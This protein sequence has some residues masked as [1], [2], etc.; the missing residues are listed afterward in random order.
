M[1]YALTHANIYLDPGRFAEALLV[2]DGLIRAVGTDQEIEALAP[3]ETIDC[4]G[5]TLIPGFNDSHSHLLMV[6][7]NGQKLQLLD[8]QSIDEI[9][10]K[11]REFIQQRP[12]LTALVGMG[13]NPAEFS[14]GEKRNLHRYDLD[15][16]STEIPVML[17][18]AC[19]HTL[20][21][22]TKALEMAGV[23]KDTPQIDGGL[24]E[25]DDN[26]PN[27]RFFENARELVDHLQPTMTSEDLFQSMSETMNYALSNGITTVQTNDIGMVR[28]LEDTLK[29][30]RDLYAG[31]TPTIKT[32]HQL[33]FDTPQDFEKFI[34]STYQEELPAKMTWGPLKLFKDGTLGGRSALVS[35]AFL[36]SPGNTG[37][38]VLPIAKAK[39]F[40]DMAR[41]HGFQVYTHCIG[42]KAIEEMLEVYQPH[43]KDDRWALVHCQITHADTLEKMAEAG[44][45]AIIQPIFL[46][47]DVG[48]LQEALSPETQ[49]TSYAWKTMLKLGIPIAIGTDSPVEDLNPFMNLYTALKRR[50]PKGEFDSY[51]PEQQLTIEEAIDGYTLGS[52]YAEGKE[53]QKGRLKPGYQADMVLLD[54][55][56]FDI[57]PEEIL[58]TRVLKTFV[59]GELLYQAD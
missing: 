35:E 25:I 52:A 8:S 18:S 14:Q 22:N 33:C 16:I 7:E 13:W 15:K 53:N 46:R 3:D 36:D 4:Q 27:G 12:D 56:I 37:L 26:G 45:T 59:D 30:Y 6:T 50:N 57:T 38:D 40:V 1:K 48:P 19:A 23:T 32:N 28:P 49:A 5:H 21:C 42:D 31:D 54:R 39:G 29:I 51:F 11:G 17:T 43:S 24:F 9:I 41:K 20:V 58:E 34:H 10:D 55:N 2:E 44:V 47:V